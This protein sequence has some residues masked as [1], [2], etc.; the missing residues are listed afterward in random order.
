[1][2]KEIEVKVLDI[3]PE[4]IEKILIKLDAKLIKKEHQVNTIFMG[5]DE[6]IE[7]VGK[8]YLR[9][10]ESKNLLDGN[11]DY[12]LTYKRNISQEGF[13]ENEETET[14][15][16]DKDSLIKILSLMDINV[17]NEGRKDRTRYQLDDIKFDI[18]IWDAETYPHPYLEIEVKDPKDIKRALDL[19]DIDESK[20]TTKSLKELRSELGK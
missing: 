18:D 14:K 4:N 20:A 3:D 6:D 8:G 15:V 5:I 7:D 9:I 1:M 12:T 16:E 13:R 19:L 10:R 11:I 2:S 17:K